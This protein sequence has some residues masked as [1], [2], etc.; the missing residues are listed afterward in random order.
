MITLCISL[1][2]CVK[3]NVKDRSKISYGRQC[4]PFFWN[5]GGGGS[6]GRSVNLKFFMV[7]FSPNSWNPGSATAVYT[8][9]WQGKVILHFTSL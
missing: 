9:S 7:I 3:W 2:I 1:C 4:W 6:K 8:Y 5:C